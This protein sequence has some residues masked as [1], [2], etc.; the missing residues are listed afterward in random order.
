MVT[1]KLVHL[2]NWDQPETGEGNSTDAVSGMYATS[3]APRVKP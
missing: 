3:S 1:L 2:L